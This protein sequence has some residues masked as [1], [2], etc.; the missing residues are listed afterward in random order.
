MFFFV[1][2]LLYKVGERYK[3]RGLSSILSLFHTDFDKF[4][5]TGT[6]MLDY[7]KITLKSVCLFVCL[8]WGG[9]CFC[10]LLL[11]F[12]CCCCCENGTILSICTQRCYARHCII[13]QSM[14]E[15]M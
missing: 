3:M 7:I 10:F 13:L 6:R 4:N 15:V 12:F 1:F 8:F 5:N 2:N 11:C 14:H 9:G